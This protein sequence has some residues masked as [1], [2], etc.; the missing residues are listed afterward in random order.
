ALGAGSA[1]LNHAAGRAAEPSSRLDWRRGSRRAARDDHVSRPT[2]LR[3]R[4]RRTHLGPS[5]VKSLSFAFLPPQLLFVDRRN[6]SPIQKFFRRR[7]RNRWRP[8]LS[9]RAISSGGTQ[10]RKLLLSTTLT[11]PALSAFRASALLPPRNAPAQHVNQ[12]T[13]SAAQ[14]STSPVPAA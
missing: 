1:A 5:E 10:M 2:P 7:A 4:G 14:Q 9:V 6:C 11:P 3:Y 12:G 13:H 8:V